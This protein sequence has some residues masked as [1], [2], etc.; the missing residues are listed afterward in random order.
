M[1]TLPQYLEGRKKA[2]FA[3]QIGVSPTQLSQYLSGYRRPSYEMMMLIEAATGGDV[4]AQSWANIGDH[5][6]TPPAQA[7][8]RKGA[9]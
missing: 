9:A 6:P 3:Q 4:K 1:Q 5:P 8:G 2:D 7:P